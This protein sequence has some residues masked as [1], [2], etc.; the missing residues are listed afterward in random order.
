MLTYW[1]WR[2][3]VNTTLVASGANQTLTRFLRNEMRQLKRYGGKPNV[4][5]CG[6]DFINALDIEITDKGLFTQ[7]GWTKE[8]ATDFGANKFKLMGLGTFEYDPTLDDLG[9]SKYCYIMDNR[10]IKLRPMQG[11]DNKLRMPERPYNYFVFLK[12]M[13]WTGG[14]TCTQLNANAVYAI[15]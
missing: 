12:S 5:L 1:W 3:R 2:H 4:A 9:Y 15:A 6:N 11:E 14:M 10:R 7:E 13:T 8:K